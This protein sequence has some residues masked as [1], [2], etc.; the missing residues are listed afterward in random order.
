[1]VN[2]FRSFARL[3]T[4]LRRL[5]H[6][7]LS[8]KKPMTMPGRSPWTPYGARGGFEACWVAGAALRRGGP[9]GV[10]VH[11]ASSPYAPSSLRPARDR[12]AALGRSDRPC[13]PTRR[14]LR[15]DDTPRTARPPRPH[16]ACALA[17]SG[18]QVPA[19]LGHSPPAQKTLIRIL[20]QNAKASHRGNIR[21][22][23]SS[24][25]TTLIA[26]SPRSAPSALPSG[27]PAWPESPPATRSKRAFPAPLSRRAMPGRISRHRSG[28]SP[29]LRAKRVFGDEPGTAAFGRRSGRM[30]MPPARRAAARLETS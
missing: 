11:G 21:V 4:A 25:W 19:L 7:S 24:A 5:C 10:R 14:G 18:T 29:L 17:A 28:L 9:G 22:P 30:A 16:H 15:D 2:G 3:G 1:M 8:T 12:A 23:G 6:R 27:S 20:R 13:P 26:R